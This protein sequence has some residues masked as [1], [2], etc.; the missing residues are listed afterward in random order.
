[1]DNGASVGLILSWTIKL[2][3][4]NGILKIGMNGLS[5]ANLVQH[6]AM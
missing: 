4:F 3:D 5:I 1:M 2:F 6:Y